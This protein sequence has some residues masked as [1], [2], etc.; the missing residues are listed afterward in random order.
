[1]AQ[2]LPLCPHPDLK[3]LLAFAAPSAWEVMYVAGSAP[4]FS[5][6]ELCGDSQKL[7]ASTDLE[8]RSAGDSSSH[9]T[10]DDDSWVGAHVARGQ[11]HV[12]ET[13]EGDICYDKTGER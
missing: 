11:G 13:G 3:L 9:A 1:M 7:Q 8:E 12:Q 10:T 5:E 2:E 6:D 4:L